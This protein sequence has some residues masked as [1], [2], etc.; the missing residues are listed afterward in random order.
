MST[1]RTSNEIEQEIIHLK[2]RAAE[3]LR[4]SKRSGSIG[5]EARKTLIGILGDRYT[6]GSIQ[7]LD[8]ELAKQKLVETSASLPKVVFVRPWSKAFVVAKVTKK[9]IFIRERDSE[10]CITF[11][12]DGSRVSGFGSRIDLAATFAG[13]HAKM[14]EGK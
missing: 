2:R 10:K 1:Q 12:R 7:L 3:A 8:R 9:L 13:E 5:K 14:L 6:Y 11:R 4:L